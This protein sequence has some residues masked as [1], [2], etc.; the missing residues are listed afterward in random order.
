MWQASRHSCAACGFECDSSAYCALLQRSRSQLVSCGPDESDE[1]LGLCL[2]ATALRDEILDAGFDDTLHAAVG[3]AS[4]RNDLA[5]IDGTKD[6]LTSFQL[7]DGRPTLKGLAGRRHMQAGHDDRL[8]LI[9]RGL[10]CHQRD[11]DAA[12]VGANEPS[13]RAN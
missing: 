1:L 13:A 7:C 11:N 3:K 5:L 4:G 8:S 2:A 12:L 9:L 6:R 10:R